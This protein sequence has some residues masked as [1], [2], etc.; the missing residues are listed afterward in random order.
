[1]V[2]LKTCREGSEIEENKKKR[3]K[4]EKTINVKPNIS[5]S[6]VSSSKED[7]IMRI[8]TLLWKPEFNHQMTLHA[9]SK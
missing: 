2:A 8:K 1:M 5:L 4:R 7:D 6:H 3:K 9:S